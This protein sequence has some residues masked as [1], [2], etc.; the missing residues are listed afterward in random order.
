[1]DLYDVLLVV[2]SPSC[3]LNNS[4][5]VNLTGSRMPLC[6]H[7]FGSIMRAGVID[8]GDLLFY[9]SKLEK[10]YILHVNIFFIFHGDCNK[11]V[12]LSES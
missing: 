3:C 4:R 9:M 2:P 1:M 12:C 7:P 8:V 10:V 6:E 11:A 5:L